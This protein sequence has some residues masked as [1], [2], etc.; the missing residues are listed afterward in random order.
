MKNYQ[1]LKANGREHLT[2][3]RMKLKALVLTGEG[4]NCDKETAVAFELAGM[5]TQR[6]HVNDLIANPKLLGEFHSLAFPGGFSFGDDLGAGK[7]FANKIVNA[8][9]SGGRLFDCLE[10]FIEAEKTVIGICNGFQVLVKSGLLPALGGKYGEQQVTV[11]YNDSNRYENRWVKTR[12]L[13]SPCKFSVGINSIGVPCRHGEGKFIAEEKTMRELWKKKL[14]VMQYVDKE[15]KPTMDFP[16]NPNG[17]MDSIAGIC[18]EKGNVFGL[19]PHPE[20]F[21]FSTNSPEWTR[22]QTTGEGLKFFVNAVNYLKKEF[23]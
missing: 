21:V 22:S 20:A 11:F 6:I 17:S 13:D 23:G 8:A 1:N 7:A 19:M 10:E 5:S 15:E 12:V 9:S 3:E 18:N 14:V 16:E 4:I 2:G